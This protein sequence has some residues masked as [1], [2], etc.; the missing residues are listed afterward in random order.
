MCQMVR[1]AIVAL[2]LALVDVRADTPPARTQEATL[3]QTLKEVI[4]KGADLY[5]GGDPAACYR[6]FEG[7]LMSLK[8]M[9]ENRP[10]LQKTIAK[11]LASAE[12]DPLM[13]RRAFTLRDALDKVR[14][15]INPNR[16]KDKAKPPIENKSGENLPMPKAD[17]KKDEGKP[18]EKK[19]ETS[20]DE[21][22]VDKLKRDDTEKEEAKKDEAKK[23]EAKTDEK[24]QATEKKD[25]A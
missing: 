22:K 11:A 12:K 15:E 3:F 8:P 1:L 9:L 25:E 2:G 5:N 4:N 16:S 19:G 10:E 21:S 17:E 14:G 13:W 20:K 6:L 18:P 7:S 23:D 24:S